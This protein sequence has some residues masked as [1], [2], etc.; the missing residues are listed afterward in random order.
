M[1]DS[2]PRPLNFGFDPK[3]TKERMFYRFERMVE[4][5]VKPYPMVYDR[6]RK[7]LREFARWVT[8]GLYR[9]IAFADY[10]VSYRS[11]N[12]PHDAQQQLVI[13]AS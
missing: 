3:E 2:M 4:R 13:L 8:T 1:I 7:D 12:Q 6:N 10:R 5:G 9:T 11:A